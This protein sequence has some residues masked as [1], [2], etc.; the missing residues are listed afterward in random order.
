[1]NRGQI[2]IA[3]LLVANLAATIWF[4][5]TNKSSS[6]GQVSTVQG[7]KL[8]DEA[9]KQKLFDKFK[10]AF[11]MRD[12]DA[13]YDMLG[14]VAKNSVER[15][16]I[17]EEFQKLIR[18]FRRIESGAFSHSESI[19]KERGFRA[20]TLNYQVRLSEDSEF[21]QKGHLKISVLARDDQIEIYGIRLTGG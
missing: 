11:N 17:K 9:T 2:I 10:V 3:L 16:K 6:A 20:V 15:K 12:Y 18:Y 1:M 7:D 5:I 8:V 14:P 13:I 21:G 4:G 19:G